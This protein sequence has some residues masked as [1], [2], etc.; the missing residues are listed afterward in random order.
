MIL[1]M[2]KFDRSGPSSELLRTFCVVAEVGNVTQAATELA[3]TQ[4]AIS[5]QINKLEEHLQV[6]LF[7]DKKVFCDCKHKLR[8]SFITVS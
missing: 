1:I 6:K 4:S 2:N 7:E 3:R 8:I 5:V